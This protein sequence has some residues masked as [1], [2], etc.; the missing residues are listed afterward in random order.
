MDWVHGHYAPQ[1]LIFNEPLKDGRFGIRILK[2]Q[3]QQRRRP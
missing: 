2:R 3:E 1:T